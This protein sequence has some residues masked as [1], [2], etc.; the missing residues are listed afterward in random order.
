MSPDRRREPIRS[1][2]PPS[3]SRP[4]RCWSTTQGTD[5]T[6]HGIKV[7]ERMAAGLPIDHDHDPSTSEE[8]SPEQP[9]LYTENG[10]IEEFRLMDRVRY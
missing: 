4:A 5:E 6:N 10:L 9:S 7:I 3:P 8:L 2:C 1:R